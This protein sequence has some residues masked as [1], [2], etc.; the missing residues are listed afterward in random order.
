MAFNH[1]IKVPTQYKQASKILQKYEQEGASM[2]NMIYNQK[3]AKINRLCGLM[4]KILQRKP[5]LDAVIEKSEILQKEER[6]NPHL[7]KILIAELLFG[8]GR[9]L[10][11]S[12]PVQTVLSYEK[13]LRKV[14]E[15]CT[16]QSPELVKA[17]ENLNLPRYVRINTLKVKPREILEYLTMNDGW[18]QIPAAGSYDEFLEI[19]K[20]LQEAE[21]IEDYHVS[22]L[23]AFPASSRS[24]WA[25]HHLVEDLSVVLQNKSSC[26]A[27][28]LLAPMRKCQVLDM[29]SAPGMKTIQMAAM[30][31]NKG[32]IYAAENH[33]G[34]FET[35]EKFARDS[36][37]T[38]IQP[39][40]MDSLRIREEHVP[41]IEY[42]LL[43]PSCSGSGVILQ[44]QT[45]E[46]TEY[47]EER[48]RKLSFLQLKL[49]C[50][51]MKNFPSVRRIVYSTCSTNIQEN[52]MVVQQALKQFKNFKI[53]CPLEL[54]RNEWKSFGSAAVKKIGKK[55]IYARPEVDS[56]NGFFI[57][58][59]ERKEELPMETDDVTEN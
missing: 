58:V 44:V 23:F 22:N 24:Y 37:S 55:C 19:V 45:R 38:I 40:N 16:E 11:T 52:E 8:S 4:T 42:I 41:N 12:K 15:K 57:A 20:N 33:T 48:I 14:Y 25:T 18:R 39:M 6:L 31:K 56:T 17:Q 29:C 7:A 36:G 21:F 13:K 9:L 28:L 43:D 35:L 53:K 3:H 59:L 51:A 46:R 50:H 1:S 34:R 2:R 10:G 49:L 5:L 27:P 30:M 26:L 32:V 54:L 47:D